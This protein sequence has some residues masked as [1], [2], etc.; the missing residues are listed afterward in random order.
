MLSLSWQLDIDKKISQ[1][2]ANILIL[3]RRRQLWNREEDVWFVS[4][5]MIFE[6]VGEV[7]QL[8]YQV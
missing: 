4:T 1:R 8:Y 3:D 7:F 6:F 2:Q 5:E